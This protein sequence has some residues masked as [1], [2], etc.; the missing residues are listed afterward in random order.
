M[1][2]SVDNATAQLALSLG[3]Q[4][5]CSLSKVSQSDNPVYKLVNNSKKYEPC[6]L[7]VTN[8]P[9]GTQMQTYWQYQNNT[10]SNLVVNGKFT[11]NNNV[12][13]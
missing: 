5:Y 2:F 13:T 11:I 8:A 1:Y 4:S 6:T 7:V 12:L 9:N 10:S 3:S